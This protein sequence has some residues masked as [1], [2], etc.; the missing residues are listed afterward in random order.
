MKSKKYLNKDFE[1][2]CDWF[3][4]KYIDTNYIHQMNI[5]YSQINITQHSQVISWVRVRRDNI[6]W[7]SGTKGYKQNKWE[8]KISL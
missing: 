2:I 3:L 8:I 5:R 4:D 1:N 6:G 7:T